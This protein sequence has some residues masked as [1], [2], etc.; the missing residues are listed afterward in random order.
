MKRIIFI[1]IVCLALSSCNQTFTC[2]SL[3]SQRGTLID[4]IEDAKDAQTKSH[5]CSELSRTDSLM[6]VICK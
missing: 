4:K 3:A 6:M 2:E 5:I 1:A